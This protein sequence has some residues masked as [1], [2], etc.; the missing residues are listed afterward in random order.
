MRSI[1]TDLEEYG[2]HTVS[3]STLYRDEYSDIAEQFVLPA[4]EEKA[5][6]APGSILSVTRWEVLWRDSTCKIP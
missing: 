2:Y 4:I 5:K 3:N 1:A 6:G